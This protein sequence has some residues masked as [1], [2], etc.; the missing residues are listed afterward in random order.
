M[1]GKR[2][3]LSGFIQVQSKK[4]PGTKHFALRTRL[5]GRFL[6]GG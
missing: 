6:G 3:D 1:E 2:A 4:Q 5:L